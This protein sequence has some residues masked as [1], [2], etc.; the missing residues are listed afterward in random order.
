MIRGVHHIAIAV[1]DLEA[2]LPLYKER[3]GFQLHAIERVPDQRVRVAV[4]VNGPHRIELVEPADAS[5]PISGF[6]ERRGPGLH[7][8]CLDVQGIDP[9]LADLGAA[10]IRL[11]DAAPRPGAEG[12]RV[13]FVHPKSTGGVLTEFCQSRDADA[14]GP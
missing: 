14:A 8:I 5:S 12:R 6:L 3:F 10:G 9:L 7:H 2:A 11:I 4:L 13:A 1:P